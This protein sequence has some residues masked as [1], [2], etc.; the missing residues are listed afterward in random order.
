MASRFAGHDES[1][2]DLMGRLDSGEGVE[3]CGYEMTP[4]MAEALRTSTAYGL[5]RL[6]RCR[7]DVMEFKSSARGGVS[8]PSR[9]LVER[10]NAN[11]IEAGCTMIVADAFWTTQEIT[12]PPEVADGTAA[13]LVPEQAAIPR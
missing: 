5:V 13:L 9:K 12:A 11:G 4:A 2:A 3:V 7:V 8:L 1:Q 6:E 10:L